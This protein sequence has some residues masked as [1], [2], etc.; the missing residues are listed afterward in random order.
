ML[1]LR[2]LAV[3]LIA[4]IISGFASTMYFYGQYTAISGRYEELSRSH[5][6]LKEDYGSLQTEYT[7]LMANYT[8]LRESYTSLNDRYGRLQA[9]YTLLDGLYMSLK[10]SYSKLEREYT[11]LRSDY[12]RLDESY[13]SLSYKYAELEKTYRDLKSSFE[14][15]QT[16]YAKLE[17][18]YTALQGSYNRLVRSYED[19]RRYA[20]SYIFLEDS[21][22]RVLSGS[23]ISGL[24]LLVRSIVS[25]PSDYWRSVRELYDY[26]RRNVKYV[27]DPPLPYPPSISDLERGMYMKMTFGSVILAPSETLTLRQGDCEDQAILL[28]ALIR[29]YQRYIYGREYILWLIYITLR[30]GTRHVAVAYPVEGGR[31]T[32]LDPAGA[33][34]TGY[35]WS[36]SSEDPFKEFD[37]YS[38]WFGGH[39]G[40]STITIYNV[41]DGIL[42]KVVEGS[43][44]EVAYYVKYR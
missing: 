14:S 9:N 31:L 6:K 19:W 15:L 34:Y 42:I 41:L 32:I 12:R 26:I 37:R 23:E 11:T 8:L 25:Y 16:S 18:M 5:D 1:K 17:S 21:V 10:E 4:S 33:Y 38:S 24:T 13:R 27:Y 29:C 7:L 43:V 36:L 2:I 35:P 28:Y 30:D 39:G 44:Y 40:I 3:A 20:L 22:S